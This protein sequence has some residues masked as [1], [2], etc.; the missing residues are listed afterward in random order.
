MDPELNHLVSSKFV[1]DW[2]GL[3]NANAS[4]VNICSGLMLSKFLHL[5]EADGS[6]LD[7]G[8]WRP[9]QVEFGAVPLFMSSFLTIE[10]FP[11]SS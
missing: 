4:D 3:N 9:H 11:F 1:C 8:L 7:Y 2:I 10:T 6:G 5:G